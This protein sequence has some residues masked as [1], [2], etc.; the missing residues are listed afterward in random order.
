MMLITQPEGQCWVLKA[1]TTPNTTL[2]DC[3]FWQKSQIAST[4]SRN[5]LK[6]E[7]EIWYAPKKKSP[8]PP[9]ERQLIEFNWP[10]QTTSIITENIQA[11][12][13]PHVDTVPTKCR[14]KS[15]GRI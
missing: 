8:K 11:L 13:V 6:K 3:K 5:F 4:P 1:L 7:G 12:Q 14:T 10:D 9:R 15:Q 2:D